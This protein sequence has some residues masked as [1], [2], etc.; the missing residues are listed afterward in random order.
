MVQKKKVC[1]GLTHSSNTIMV[2][3]HLPPPPP[4]PSR[5]EKPQWKG[6]TQIETN[7]V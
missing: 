4:P 6:E 2:A 7:T 3:T 1:S 5:G